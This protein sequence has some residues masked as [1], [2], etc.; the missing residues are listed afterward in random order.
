M[1]SIDGSQGEGG[2]Q[3]LR[4]ALA[5]SLITG[6]PFRIEN[7]RA[8]RAKPG[9]LRQHLTAV[10]AAAEI[11]GSEITGDELG[12]HEL[13]VRPGAVRA[14][15]YRFAVGSAGS[16]CLV[17]QTVLPALLGANEPSH[18]TLEG[19]THNPAAPTWDY[20]ARVFAP[21]LERMGATLRTELDRHGFY[22][23]GGGQFRVEIAP[24]RQLAPLE[25]LAR[26]EPRA[27]R[28]RALIAHL[29]PEIGERELRVLRSKVSGLGDAATIVA[30]KSPGPGNALSVELAYEHVTEVFTGFGER[31]V[32]AESVA[33]K[34]ANEVRRYL[35]SDAPVGPHLADQLV[36]PLAL[37]GGGVF[38]TLALTPHTVTNIDIVQRFLPVRLRCTNEENGAVRVEVTSR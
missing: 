30:A 26:G 7:I 6:T 16:A 29:D 14:G 22:P 9:L 24:A 35:V 37:S 20:V 23:A 32:R 2:G 10:R 25:L 18:L 13:V 28:A 19:G 21:L 8:G 5:L 34:L 4:S 17:L 1:L 3:I 11:S 12:S 33:Q 27:R 38:R 36:L 15:T 31:M